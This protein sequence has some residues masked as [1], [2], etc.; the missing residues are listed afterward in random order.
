MKI[1]A[2]NTCDL[3]ERKPTLAEA[4]IKYQADRAQL[5]R[6]YEG[7]SLDA[8]YRRQADILHRELSAEVE[9]SIPFGSVAEV[10]AALALERSLLMEF[11]GDDLTG[12]NAAR[13][14]ILEGAQ[15]FLNRPPVN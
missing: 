6:S 7:R 5:L 9:R 1:N 8:A 10:A 14:G 13:L 12:I 15:A 2:E 4:A 3:S 11:E